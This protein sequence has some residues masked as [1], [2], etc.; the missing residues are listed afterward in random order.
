[1]IHKMIK[2]FF[3]FVFL[4]NFSSVFAYDWSEVRDI[5]KSGIKENTLPG[6]VLLIG[7]KKEVL[8]DEAF[9]SI[10]KT[11]P[12]NALATIYDVASLTKVVA[13]TTSI[14]LLEEQGKLS[15]HDRVSKYYPEFVGSQKENVTIEQVMRHQAGFPSGQTPEIN[16][17]L[18]E[19][20]KRFLGAPLTY[21]PG[22]KFIYS[23]LGFIL[24]AQIVEKV[25][26]QNIEEFAT[27]NIFKPLEMNSS[28]YHVPSELKKFCAPTVANRIK[29][30]PHD[31]TAYH[32]LKNPIGNAGVF[33]TAEN[34]SH[35][36]QMY[37]NEGM[38]KNKSFLKKETVHNMISLP[39]DQ[40]RG[41]GFDL[42]SPYA[43]SPRGDY[44]PKGISYGH[45]GYTGTS[46]W[47]DP[48]SGS[49]LVFL[50]NRVFLG[51]EMTSKKFIKLRRDVS[52]AVG[53]QIYSH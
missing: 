45:T 8:L 36:A 39:P 34:L 18:K 40:I 38:Y 35:L 10:D 16:E 9:G 25:S 5:I 52:T 50:A 2:L 27:N 19:Y 15:L 43:E 4:F 14:M 37:L 48:A 31:P 29:C 28:F 6:G 42:L 23:D 41:L 30:L 46:M 51:D 13:T 24:L 7:N 12:V 21:S 11:Q 44:F 33:S 26:S 32:F 1:M 3:L 17:S 53:K 49:Y 22:A 20:T 47:I